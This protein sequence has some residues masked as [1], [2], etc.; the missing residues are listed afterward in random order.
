MNTAEKIQMFQNVFAPKPA[1][2]VLFIVDMPHGTIHDNSAWND[3]RNMA[4]EWY[5]IFKQ[6]G[7]TAG[8]S[9]DWFEY[10]A[11]GVHNTL[12]PQRV[13]ERIR[14]SNLVIAMTEYS[15]SSS[16]L[17]IARAKDTVTRCASMPQV[18]RRMEE[19]AFRADYQLVKKYA[20]ALAKM[21]NE[22]IGAEV[23]FSTD[24]T[25][26]IDLRH[27]IADADTG[28]C[29]HP[30]QAINF[31][32]GEACKVPYEAVSEEIS[33]FGASQTQGIWPVSIN[34][35]L[36]K[37]C[38]KENRIIDILG[39]GK[40]ADAMRIFF[41]ENDSR[42]NIAELGVGC[43]PNAV[44]TGNILEDEKVGLHIAYGMST[45]LHG[46]VTSD[47][48]MDFCYSKGCP[49]EGT[50]VFLLRNDGSKTELIRNAMLRYELLQ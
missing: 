5:M 46:R 17:P 12:L 43:N 6:M 7:A 22:A 30:G 26:Y 20:I 16:L 8:F 47:T 49:V 27:R 45:H 34:G 29:I 3:R 33:E 11:M 21:L 14:R 42:R 44:V 39:A 24:D 36:M 50:S 19:T 28:E 1:E 31:P 32:S 35:E 41:A 38:V 10:T 4:R 13:L 18:A 40:E 2:E 23:V 15:V 37:F 9:V 25:L 48:H